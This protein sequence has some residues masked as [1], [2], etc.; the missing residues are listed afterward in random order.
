MTEAAPTSSFSSN[1]GHASPIVVVSCVQKSVIDADDLGGC[2]HLFL[3]DYL[4]T[5]ELR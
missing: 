5:K 4:V 3:H 1:S 2:R